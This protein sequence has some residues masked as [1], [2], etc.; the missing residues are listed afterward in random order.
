MRETQEAPS[1]DLSRV[2]LFAGAGSIVGC[3]TGIALAMAFKYG[4]ISCPIYGFFGGTLLGGAVGFGRDG[5]I[6]IASKLLRPT[7]TAQT[8]ATAE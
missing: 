8:G 3:G 1:P 5:F 4:G 2:V 6:G 7:P